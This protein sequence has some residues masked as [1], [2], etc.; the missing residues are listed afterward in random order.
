[1]A[2]AEKTTPEIEPEASPG[3]AAPT[4]NR[5]PP[6][7]RG[8]PKAGTDRVPMIESFWRKI[9]SIASEDWGT[10]ANI[11][12]YRDRPVLDKA[13]P[14]NPKKIGKFGFKITEEWLKENHGSG[15]YRCYLTF[16]EP[17]ADE[18]EIDT[19][20]VHIF[21]PKYPPNV[22]Y[23]M[24]VVCPEN[25]DWEWC[26]PLLKK[27]HFGPEQAAPGN[28]THDVLETFRTFNEIQDTLAARVQQPAAAP[29]PPAAPI[30]SAADSLTQGLAMVQQIMSMKADNPMVDMMKDE[31]KGMREEMRA[32][33]EE[34]RKLQAEIRQ[35]ANAKP[36]EKSGMDVLRETIKTVKEELLPSV[37]ELLP[38]ITEGATRSRMGSWQE[39]FVAMA[40]TVKDLVT[41]MFNRMAMGGMGTLAAAPQLNPGTPAAPPNQAPHM[42]L[43]FLKAYAP[44]LLSYLADGE[45]GGSFADY[46][47]TGCGSD[48]NGVQWLILKQTIGTA[49]LVDLFKRSPYGTKIE[50]VVG[51]PT[52]TP[53]AKEAKF[54][55]FIEQFVA[56]QPEPE[57]PADEGV[58]DLSQAEEATA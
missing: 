40:P 43:E 3:G 1:M 31:M 53:V 32:E 24:F 17:Q 13:R 42:E 20:A 54:R 7:H 8:R 29:Q 9:E 28:A 39:F 4:Q 57:G 2:K 15:S 35:A 50:A 26:R 55:A 27:A 16:K 52:D 25:T 36:A 44:A 12:V 5:M 30:Q 34:N 22:P 51:E 6:R 33:R 41:P 48:W 11:A 14:G 58:I 10:R 19:I 49:N 37:K 21:D 56:W 45:T 18:R 23:E 46:I 38:Q 47:F